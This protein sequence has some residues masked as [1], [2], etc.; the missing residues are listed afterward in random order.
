MNNIKAIRKEQGISVTELA[1][2]LNM[3]QSNLT[4]IENNQIELKTDMAVKIANILG[5]SVQAIENEPRHHNGMVSIRLINPEIL[6]LPPLSSVEIP[7]QMQN[8][9]KDA[10]ILY[11]MN[12]DTMSPKIPLNALVLINQN[13]KTTGNGVYLVK[14]NN[15]LYLRRLQNTFSTK[16]TYL[17]CDNPSYEPQQI[18]TSLVEIIGKA[19]SYFSLTAI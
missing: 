14:I 17:L 13:Q 7:A 8:I 3:S 1:L 15:N 12:D 11:V 5:V 10:A 16:E 9:H 18:D 6:N 4:K 19:T 2:K